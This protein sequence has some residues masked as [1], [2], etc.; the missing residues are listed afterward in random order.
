MKGIGRYF[1]ALKTEL[2]TCSN[3][4]FHF[5]RSNIR[6]IYDWQDRAADWKVIKRT[7]VGNQLVIS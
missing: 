5:R 1:V 7:K 4:T 2:R 6:Y 3:N